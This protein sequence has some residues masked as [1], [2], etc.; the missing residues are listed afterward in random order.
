MKSLNQ[1][2]RKNAW[3]AVPLLAPAPEAK[4]ASEP[5]IAVKVPPEAVDQARSPIGFTP[6]L[7]P[8]YVQFVAFCDLIFSVQLLFALIVKLGPPSAMTLPRRRRQPSD[9][10]AL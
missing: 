6:E 9:S 4:V 5:V 1:L 7:L 3:A 8:T 2:V 10:S